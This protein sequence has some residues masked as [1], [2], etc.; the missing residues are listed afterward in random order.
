MSC[1]LVL[2]VTGCTY[3]V[4]VQPAPATA[5]YTSYA[6][7][8]SGKFALYIDASKMNTQA[9]PLGQ[10]CSLNKFPINASEAFKTSTVKTFQKVVQT[11]DVVDAPLKKEELAGKGYRGLITVHAD[12]FVVHMGVIPGFWTVTIEG[13]ASLSVGVLV[14]GS[15]DRLFGASVSSD[16]SAEKRTGGGCGVGADAISIAITAAI[17]DAL[18]QIAG[19][20]DEAPK[21]RQPTSTGSNS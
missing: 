9:E 10:A 1:L 12:N 20:V 18:E 15:S 14:D 17:K 2:L 8:I 5:E 21:L 6:D 4:A 13:D 3:Q 11:V 16:R 7:K 19:R